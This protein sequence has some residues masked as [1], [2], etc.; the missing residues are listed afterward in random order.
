L[1]TGLL[2]IVTAVLEVDIGVAL[3]VSPASTVKLTLRAL[4]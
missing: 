1:K 2:F 3:P 4:P